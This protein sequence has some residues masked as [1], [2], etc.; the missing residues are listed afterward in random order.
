MIH[1][2][3]NFINELKS[4]T[5]K[6]AG[7][8]LINLGH[9]ERGN[10]LLDYSKK[11]YGYI[12][13][14]DESNNINEINISDIYKVKVK[15]SYKIKFYTKKNGYLILK[16]KPDN[17]DKTVDFDDPNNPINFIVIETK[18]VDRKSAYKLWKYLKDNNIIVNL[19]SL[20][21]EKKIDTGLLSVKNYNDS[22]TNNHILDEFF[23][24]NESSLCN[25]NY[26]KVLYI[27]KNSYSYIE[28][29]INKYKY[30]FKWIN[31][32]DFLPYLKKYLSHISEFYIL[33]NEHNQLFEQIAIDNC[34]KVLDFR[35]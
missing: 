14:V 29:Y 3:N 30:K 11:D 28:N 24:Y 1:K 23:I 33:L 19:N 21:K 2:F 4:S 9:K 13:Y 16:L 12:N 35:K 15:K 10:N 6:S 32:E 27:N 18:L 7:K 31:N 34:Y 5:Y 22:L 20:Y 8:K 26:E 17:N 25:T